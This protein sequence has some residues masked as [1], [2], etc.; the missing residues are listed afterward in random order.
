MKP[1]APSDVFQYVED[2]IGNFNTA[3]KVLRTSNARINVEAVNGCC[4]GRD[5]HPYKEAGYVKYCGQRFWEF[6]SGD[7]SFFTEII[8]PLGHQ[9]KERNEEFEEAYNKMLNRFTLEFGEKFCNA[10]GSIDWEALVKLNSS[11]Q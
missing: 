2:N 1:L 10:D 8:E 4:Y 6:I 11:A 5:D 7:S 3:K 9:A